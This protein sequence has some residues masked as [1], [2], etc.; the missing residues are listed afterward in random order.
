[1]SQQIVKPRGRC[2][3]N[4]I[5]TF[6]SLILARTLPAPFHP[7]MRSSCRV[8]A[9]NTGR[10][11]PHRK[12]MTLCAAHPLFC[13]Y[14]HSFKMP[15][16]CTETHALKYES[17]HYSYCSPG[18]VMFWGMLVQWPAHPIAHIPNK[19]N[20]MWQGHSYWRKGGVMQLTSFPCKSFLFTPF[21]KCF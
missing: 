8:H 3:F 9:R 17:V 1:M 7:N 15:H 13:S 14:L 21:Q 16:P 11:V 2:L 20:H 6:K 19:H 18:V 12:S 10:N 5:S 4:H